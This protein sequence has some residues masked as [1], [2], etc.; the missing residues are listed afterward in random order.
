[1]A[2]YING[3]K[4]AGRGSVGPSG[5]TPYEV[6]IERDPNLSLTEE[7]YNEKLVNIGNT[8]DKTGDTM[9]GPLYLLEEIENNNNIAVHK[10]YV[11]DAIST[12]TASIVTNVWSYGEEPDNKNLFW[13]K[14]ENNGLYF[15]KNKDEGWIPV[16]ALWS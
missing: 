8:V 5:K 11:D 4:V 6:A 7:E 2:I 13:I 15:Y 12:A 3:K 16:A 10:K 1:M 14:P 9:T